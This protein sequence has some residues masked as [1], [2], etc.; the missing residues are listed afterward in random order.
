MARTTR[1]KAVKLDEI[2]FVGKGDNPE[3]HVVLLKTKKSVMTS[4]PKEYTGDKAS[5]LK[6]WMGEGRIDKDALTFDQIN[7]NK[8]IMDKI[9]S[10][11]WTLEDSISS[12]LHDDE[13]T[14]KSAMI[15]T[16]VEEFKAAVIPLT[17]GETNMDPVLKKALEDLAAA[18]A[19]VEALSKE[20]E[21]LNATVTKS[22]AQIAALTKAAEASATEDPIYKG[23]PEAVVKEMKA[24]KEEIAKMKANETRREYIGKAA[25]CTQ[26]GSADVIGDILVGVAKHD[27]AMADKILDVFKTAAARIKEGDLLKEQG[28]ETGTGVTSAYD[29]IVA[30]AAELRKTCPELSAAQA[31]TKVYD[32]EP[33]LR[34]QMEDERKA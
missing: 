9:W 25:D 23:L 27:P 17:K 10:M 29:K 20:V 18:Q 19:Q 6:K 3:A 30:K 26:V 24:N 2:S 8:A 33:E 16:S 32:A 34:Q 22:E 1:L 13:V 12:I 7:N 31:F 4:V 11:V 14:D 21:T 15:Q 28:Q 5:V